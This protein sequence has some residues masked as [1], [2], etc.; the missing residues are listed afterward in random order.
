MSGGSRLRREPGRITAEGRAGRYRGWWKFAALVLACCACARPAFF[1]SVTPPAGKILRIGN[2][3]D[4]TT[5]DPARSSGAPDEQII[6]NLFEGLVEYDPSESDPRPALAESWTTNPEATQFVFSLRRDAR[7]SNGDPVTANDLQYS[8]RRALDPGTGAAYAFMLFSIRNAKSYHARE[9]GIREQ[10]LGFRALDDHHFLVQLESP[11]AYFPRLVAQSVFRP[12]HRAT[13]ESWPGEWTTPERMVTNGPFT[14]Q[15]WRPADRV[16]LQKNPFYWNARDV[17][18]DQAIFYLSTDTYA[19][20]NLYKA[21]EIDTLVTGLLPLPY[22]RLL[23]QL[24]DYQTGPYLAT[25]F[26]VVNLKRPPLDDLRVRQALSLAVDRSLICEKLMRAGQSPARSLTPTDFDGLY[27]RPAIDAFDRD[28]AKRL[29]A[30]AGY[31]EGRGLALSL[32]FNT[33]ALHSK[34]AETIQ[35]LWR[36]AFPSIQVELVNEDWQ[37]YLDSLRRGKFDMARRFWTADYDDP[38]AFLEIMLSSNENNFTGWSSAEYDALLRQASATTDPALRMRLLSR[39]EGI[40][41]SD[42]PIIPIYSAV[43]FFLTKPY[44][45][46][47]ESQKLDRHPLKYVRLAT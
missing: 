4:P 16:I 5:L 19:L 22:I 47:W 32:L 44:V 39:A 29:L 28:R 42:L 8:W 45:R 33:S 37:V 6:I 34:I 12:V 26:Y 11:T 21:G 27:T 7:W 40:M 38:T 18:L 10:D 23:R 9:P 2:G 3:A 25:Y 13:V 30:E 20:L 24:R 15:S 1:G 41:L 46:G 14:L 17:A 36:S 35:A 31:P 43:T